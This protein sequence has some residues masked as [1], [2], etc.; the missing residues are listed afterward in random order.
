L[1]IAAFVLAGPAFAAQRAFVSTSGVN[2]PACSLLA[3]CRDFASA[4]TAVNPGGEVI[5]LDSGGFGPVTITKSVTI[6]AAPGVY[7][8]ISVLSGIGVE[9]NGAGIG[10]VLR[11]LSITGLG[12]QFGV[13]LVQGASLTVENCEIAGLMTS[14]IFVSGNAKVTVKNV[15]LRGGAGG[16]GADG[17]ITAVLDE[18]QAYDSS[19]VGIAATNGAK[20]NV[21]NS[22]IARN[23]TGVEANVAE[24]VVSHS[25]VT[26][27]ATAFSVRAGPGAGADILADANTV[28]HNGTVFSFA[29]GGGTEK[30]FTTGDNKVGF[31]LVL[32][33]GGLLEGPCCWM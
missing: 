24:L 6:A 9:I 16:F 20:V 7:A 10:V 8:G 30:I 15:V 29:V 19:F 14:S 5:A 26:G 21:R 13:R 11:G 22:I 23:T 3:P 27:S 18:V 28:T 1:V 31:W 32:V 2:N 25:I 4:V 33:S 12:G 17:A